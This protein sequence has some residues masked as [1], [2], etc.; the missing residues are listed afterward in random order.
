[1]T[2][3][4][5]IQTAVAVD[6]GGNAIDVA[7]GPLTYTGA[8]TDTAPAAG[9]GTGIGVLAIQGGSGSG[10]SGGGGCFVSAVSEDD[11]VRNNLRAIAAFGLG[12]LAAVVFIRRKLR[13]DSSA[14]L[15]FFA[16]L[17]SAL[18]SSLV[19]GQVRAEVIVQCPADTDGIDTDGDGIV[20]ND[21][22]CMHLA[23]G[24]GF[25]NM[26]DGKLQYMFGFSDVTGLMPDDVMHGDARRQLPGAHHQGQGG[27]EALPDP[28]QRGHDGAAGPL[29]PPH[30]PLPRLPQCLGHLRRAC[31]TPP[32][33]STWAP[34]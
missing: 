13:R 6:E 33:P 3:V 5:A 29:R 28:H 17:A 1:M 31:R 30:G 2:E 12:L 34:A 18:I 10:G 15:L 16:L 24:D 27:P 8:Y 20:D 23:A 9:P 19:A 21:I 14:G 22:V 26:A 4:T 32:S 7:F 25:I 11:A